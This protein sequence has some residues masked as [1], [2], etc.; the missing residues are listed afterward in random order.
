MIKVSIIVPVYNQENRIERCLE[1]LVNQTL[2]D[3]EIIVINDGSTDKSLKIIKKYLKKFPKKIKLIN[4]ENK[5]ISISRNEGIKLSKGKFIGFVDSDD[6][7]EKNMFEILYNKIVSTKTDICI[8]NYKMFYEN[9]DE[10][11]YENISKHCKIE[12]VYSNPK[13]IY[14]FH[15]APWNKLYKK[16]LWNNINFPASVKYEDL[17][18]VLKVF[19]K[20]KK[21]S[22]VENYLYNYLLNPK[23]ETAT[24]NKSVYDIFKILNN[25]KPYFLEKNIKI[26]K[27]FQE[28]YISKAF[29]YNHFILNSKDR[30]FSREY[31]N[32]AYKEINKNFKFWHI[33]YILK[34]KGPKNFIIRIIQTI[35]PIYY[36][37]INYRTK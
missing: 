29:I 28:L 17:E 6:Y 5:G 7:I 11:I 14:K 21:I 31:I 32:Y 9:S 8:C 35:K 18:A 30:K 36:L 27:A 1:S 25:L 2:N 24:V 37:Y 15:Y 33:P 22:Y 34:A 19:L 20:T 12:N 23:G 16:E 4:R 10:I 13:M 3:I 26:Q